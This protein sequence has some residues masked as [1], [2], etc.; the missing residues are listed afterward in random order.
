MFDRVYTFLKY[1]EFASTYMTVEWS[2]SSYV[3]I[4]YIYYTFGIMI[5]KV[6]VTIQVSGWCAVS[7]PSLSITQVKIYSTRYLHFVIIL[8]VKSKRL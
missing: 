2:S 3:I 7:Y 4:L 1:A 8:L 6:D 5:A